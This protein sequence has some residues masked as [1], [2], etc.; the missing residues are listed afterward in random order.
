M[1]PVDG[2]LRQLACSGCSAYLVALVLGQNREDK[3]RGGTLAFTS[4][5]VHRIQGI[6]IRTL[7][8]AVSVRLECPRGDLPTSYPTARHHLSIS[9]MKTLRS[10]VLMASW[11]YAKLVLS[12]FSWRSVSFQGV[13][14]SFGLGLE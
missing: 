5:N 3:R 12:V 6:E 11:R 4:G 7:L 13:S 14:M 8:I 10:A 1:V 2:N 9:W